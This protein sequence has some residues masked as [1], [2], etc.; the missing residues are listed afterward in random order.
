VRIYLPTT[1]AGLAE[2]VGTGLP[3]TVERFVAAEES[4]EA[5]YDALSAAAEDATALLDGPGRRVVVVAEVDDVDGA[6]RLDQ[7]VAVHADSTPVDPGARDL[8]ELGWFATQEI[9][10]LLAEDRA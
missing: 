5:E 4:E 9:D 1:P 8:P 2:L 6:V 7:V 10:D 3:A